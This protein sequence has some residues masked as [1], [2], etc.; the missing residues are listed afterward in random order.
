M[1]AEI[2]QDAGLVLRNA[3]S[4]IRVLTVRNAEVDFVLLQI[5][6]QQL[7]DDI[8]SRFAVDVT[9]EEDVDM[10]RHDSLPF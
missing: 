4:F 2:E 9:D 7:R 8:Q 1:D 5:L 10:L 3:F 6:L